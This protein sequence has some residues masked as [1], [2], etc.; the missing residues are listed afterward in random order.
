MQQGFFCNFCTV[1]CRFLQQPTNYNLFTF[2]PHRV[3]DC[4]HCSNKY[5]ELKELRAHLRNTHGTEW[6]WICG[7][8]DHL[9][10]YELEF[11]LHVREHT[12]DPPHGCPH[13]PHA[14]QETA[15]LREHLAERHMPRADD[16]ISAGDMLA[17]KKKKA[18]AADSSDAAAAAAAA[19]TAADENAVNREIAALLLNLHASRS[20]DAVVA[21]APK[22]EDL[23]V[24]TDTA[25]DLSKAKSVSAT[26]AAAAAAAAAA[27]V[28]DLSALTTPLPASITKLAKASSSS[29]GVTAATSSTSNLSI[30]S[31]P[32]SYS[33]F[34]PS[35]SSMGL[36]PSTLAT[37]NSNYLLQNLLL[38]KMQQLVSSGATTATAATSTTSSSASSPLSFPTQPLPAQALSLASAVPSTVLK[39][40][41]AV[42]KSPTSSNGSAVATAVPAAS[43]ASL[44]LP[45]V[46]N[47]GSN[48]Q[49]QLAASGAAAAAAASTSSTSPAASSSATSAT[50]IP[51]LCGQIVAQLNGL[52]FLVHSLNNS[53]VSLHV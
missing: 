25:M 9:L 27:A 29:A 51:L 22:A 31:V 41:A 46:P 8:C 45:T 23:S 44:S 21:A 3:Y 14:F 19:T 4:F 6:P 39:P 50:N 24:K 17:D 40:P 43:A 16:L 7:F 35:L 18:M 37:M 33:S 52:L 2:S 13:C 20:G 28:T 47:F 15:A 12:E 36:N 34:Y 38:G 11:R 30:T 53:Q 48:I 32:T 1:H 10:L 5:S 42:L 26:S 49:Q